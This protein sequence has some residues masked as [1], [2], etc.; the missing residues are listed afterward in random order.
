MIVSI[1]FETRSRVDLRKT[2]V[3]PYAMD[4]STDVL[5]VAWAVDDG[6][7]QCV[8]GVESLDLHMLAG[9]RDVIFSAF[10]AGFEQAIW[11]NIMAKRYGYGDIPIHRW[12]CSAAKSLS[13]SLPR[14]LG[15]VADALDLPIRKDMDGKNVM[16]KM[17]KPVP[18]NRQHLHGEWHESDED[19]EILMS[20]CKDDVDTERALVERLGFLSDEEQKI[21]EL[22]QQVNQRGIRLDT[23]LAEGLLYLKTEICD[24]LSGQCE[25]EFDFKPSQVAKLKDYLR[26]A[27]VEIP[28]VQRYKKC[29]ETGDRVKM[30]TESLGAEQIK[31]LLISDIDDDCK[32]LLQIRQDF[33]TTSLAKAQSGLNQSVDG[34]ARGQ[35]MYHGA[36]TGRWSGMG[37]QLHNLPRGDFDEDWVDEEMAVACESIRNGRFT[38]HF[39]ELRPMSV[40]KSC[41][42]GLIIPREGKQLAVLDF[43]QIEARVLAWLAGQQD[44]LDSFI[45]GKD[46]YKFT[47]SQIY[48]KE[49]NDVSKSERFIGKT[50]SLA[51][52]YQG[53]AGAFISMATNFGVLVEQDLAD[54]VKSDWRNRNDFI[55][56]FWYDLERAAVRAVKFG[57]TTKVGRIKFG[58]RDGF[59]LCKLPSGRCLAYYQPEVSTKET[60]WGTKSQLT[61]M[62]SDQQR[63]IRWGRISTYGGKLAENVTQ[64]VSRDLLANAMLNLATEYDVIGHVHD[65]VL[66]EVDPVCKLPGIT[67]MMLQLPSWADGLPVDADG[68]MGDRYRK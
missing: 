47:A 23:K 49:Y 27:G 56:R 32:Q 68:F 15:E 1:D 35:F 58:V 50:A 33:A 51:L 4:P 11:T 62:G 55:V 14:S 37:I 16:M 48:T 8:K 53:G 10:N 7:V 38:E 21:W 43:S 24:R 63:G 60:D 39:S 13:M 57:K 59:L 67:T 22:D 65:E 44:V 42:R 61:Y 34:I 12:R 45:A 36:N 31:K 30:D 29:P 25:A 54:T 64:A 3:H 19:F 5:C 17:C 46:L 28:K 66:L 26:E 9:D 52:G 40:L 2:G 20:Y 6:P 41:L 18:K